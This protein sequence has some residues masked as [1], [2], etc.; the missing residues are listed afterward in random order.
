M[1]NENFVFLGA[2]IFLFGSSGY[3]I[4]TLQGKIK[5]NRIS[6]AIWALAPLTAFAAQIAEKVDIHQSLLTFTVGAVPL[7]VLAA[8]FINKN[9]YGKLGRLDLICGILAVLGIVL[10]QVTGTGLIAIFFAI[11]ADWLGAFPTLV[12]SFRYPE[13]EN[14]ILYAANALSAIITILTIKVW[15]LATAVFPFY[16]LFMTVILTI[17]IKT[18]IGKRFSGKMAS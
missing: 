11:L 13:T 5:P 16:V 1:I 2:L 17:L 18:K 8:S 7:A 15:D 9:A 4:E 3:I 12:K 10:W 14:W 6:W